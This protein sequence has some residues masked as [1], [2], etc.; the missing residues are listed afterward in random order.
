MVLELH[1]RNHCFKWSFNN[2]IC[3]WKPNKLNPPRFGQRVQCRLKNKSHVCYPLHLLLE[4][5]S[6]SKPPRCAEIPTQRRDAALV[7]S[8]HQRGASGHPAN[9][10]SGSAAN[11]HR[12]ADV[13]DKS[14]GGR[15]SLKEGDFHPATRPLLITQR[16]RKHLMGAR[17]R[18]TG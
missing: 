2:T 18:R 5:P 11:R 1:W 17:K 16:D 15:V 9:R 12:R 10:T 13:K 3:H 14:K 6:E 8:H 4:P 7:R